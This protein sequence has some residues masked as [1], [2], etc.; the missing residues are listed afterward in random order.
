VSCS[1]PEADARGL[2]DNGPDGRGTA[3]TAGWPAAGV[4]AL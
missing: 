4:T 1:R 2:G 3:A